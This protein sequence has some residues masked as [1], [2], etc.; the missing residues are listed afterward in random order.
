MKVKI[1]GETKKYLTLEQ[2]PVAKEIIKDLTED[3]WSAKDYIKMAAGCW[4]RATHHICDAVDK[5]INAEARIAGNCRVYNALADSCG[6][7]DVW[8]EGLVKTCRGYMEIGA[9]LTDIWNIGPEE[10]NREFPMHTYTRYFTER[11]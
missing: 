10:F 5:V 4:L 3:E 1:T 6:T 9:Y 11:K 8:I 2:L 7:M